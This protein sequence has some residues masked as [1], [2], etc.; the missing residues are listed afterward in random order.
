M[1]LLPTDGPST[2]GSTAH[3]GGEIARPPL[4]RAV[5]IMQPYFCPYVGYFQLMSAVDL[6]VV[7]DNIEYTKKGWIN[8]NRILQGGRD[9]IISIPLKRDSDFLHVRDRVLATDFDRTKLLNRIRESYRRAP[10]FSQAF[11]VVEEIV[12]KQEPNLFGYLLHS[13]R[14]IC[15][16]L[17][18]DTP[19]AV[20]SSLPVDHGLRGQEKVLALCRHL[21][22]S[23]YVNAIGGVELYSREAFLDRG[24]EL[25]F[26]RPRPFEYRQFGESFVPWLSIVDVMMF[27]SAADVRRVLRSQYDLV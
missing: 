27:N 25:K 5:A 18:I 12:G 24:I 14:R 15:E 3:A 13:L 21:G 11:P 19:I 10:F 1:T 16:Y 26:L 22:A 7:Y 23:L 8:R 2:S 17:G 20:S 4:A 6:F 9:A